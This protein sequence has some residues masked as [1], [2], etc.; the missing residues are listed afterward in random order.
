MKFIAAICTFIGVLAL[1][2]CNREPNVFSDLASRQLHRRHVPLEGQSNTRDLGGYRTEDGR[3]VKWGEI[4]RTGHLGHLSDSDVEMLDALEISS[5]VSFLTAEEIEERGP[6]RLPESVKELPKPI[7][8]G[9]LGQITE[10]VS[11]ARRTGDFSKVPVELNPEIHRALMRGAKE[12]Y[13]ALLRDLIDPSNRPLIFHCSHGIHRTGTATAVLLSALGV[14]WETVREDYMLSNQYRKDEIEP[15]LGE[16]KEQAAA[17]F[18]VTVEE[19]DT[20]N[21]EAFYILKP[22]YIDAALAEAVEGY[23]SMETYIRD[24]LG[25]TDE[26]LAELR[27][28]LL[29][30]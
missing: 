8:G 9:I 23:G 11:E 2:G 5:V 26:E 22:E 30:D 29:L 28:E 14:P 7:V 24:G 3:R 10:D 27:E 16:L 6:D 4:F 21:M 15:R 12:Q 20:E 1:P 18:N 25:I 19:V 13:A 17:T